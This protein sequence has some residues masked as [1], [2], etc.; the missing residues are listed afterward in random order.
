MKTVPSCLVT[1]IVLAGCGG[2]AVEPA[3]EPAPTDPAT[4]GESPQVPWSA[5]DRDQRRQFMADVVLPTM[6]EIF[7]TFDPERYADVRCTLCHGDNARDVQFHMPNTLHPLDLE[8]FPTPESEDPRVA[9]YAEL[10]FT[11]VTPKM[12]ELLGVPPFDPETHEGFGC[13]NCHAMVQH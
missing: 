3:P 13:F 9:R 6:T 7:Q 12:V 10:M 11:Q 1:A 2:M 4:G 5:M 8:A